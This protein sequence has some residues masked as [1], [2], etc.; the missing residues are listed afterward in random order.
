MNG[1][2]G[3]G[4]GWWTSLCHGHRHMIGVGLF[5]RFWVFALICHL[6]CLL[7]LSREE[8]L[9]TPQ[10]W[11][12]K[13]VFHW[14]YILATG[15]WCWLI[16]AVKAW[17]KPSVHCLGPEVKGRLEKVWIHTCGLLLSHRVRQPGLGAALGQQQLLLSSACRRCQPWL[18][19]RGS[20]HQRREC[21]IHLPACVHSPASPHILS[22]QSRS[23][24]LLGSAINTPACS[25]VLSHAKE[26]FWKSHLVS[27]NT[28]KAQSWINK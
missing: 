5:H 20:F 14:P 18:Q 22:E 11:R 6:A 10:Q 1:Y 15:V 19:V 8:A 3:Q 23:F 21:R 28:D 24:L 12:K 2:P 27:G 26:G 13:S 9:G 17:V 4:W 16:F 7:S 25:S